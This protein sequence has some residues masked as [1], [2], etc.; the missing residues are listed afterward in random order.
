L[1]LPNLPIVIIVPRVLNDGWSLLGLGDIVLPGLWLCFLF[2]FDIVNETSFKDGYFLRS[3]IGYILGFLVTLSML[4]VM[5][6][7]QPALLYLVPFT[8]I[9]AIFF[10]WRRKELGMLWRGE[11]KEEG[12]RGSE[13]QQEE[14]QRHLLVEED[15]E[16]AGKKGTT[17]SSL[18][19]NETNNEGV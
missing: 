17:V 8:L 12:G 7:G 4:F 5:Q 3:W 11:V 2:R 6:S 10:G 16:D 18:F 14:E 19:Q 13:Q 1:S 9:P 15:S